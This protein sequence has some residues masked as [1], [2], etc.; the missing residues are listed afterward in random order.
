[1]IYFDRFDIAEAYYL[2]LTHCHGGQ[3]SP[4]YARLCHMG[5]YFKPS[6]GLCVE[7]LTDNGLEIY[8]QACTRLLKAD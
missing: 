2:A 4:A 8:Q 7:S 5:S 1:M 6:M 3:T